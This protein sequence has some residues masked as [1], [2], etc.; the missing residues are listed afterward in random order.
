MSPRPGSRHRRRARQ[1]MVAGAVVFVL[2]TLALFLARPR[3]TAYVPGQDAE[4]NREI[5]RALDRTPGPTGGSSQPGAEG[6]D[7]AAAAAAGARDA[8]PARADDGTPQ[9][10]ARAAVPGPP[11]GAAAAPAA[12]ATAAG[13]TGAGAAAAGVTFS[14]VAEA[15]GLRFT[16]FSGRRSTQLPEDMGSGLAWGDYDGDGWP[17][18]FVVNE[19]GPLTMSPAELAASPAHAQLFHNAGGRFVD[20]TEQA[21]LAVRGIGMGA[22]WGDYDGDGRLD[23][24]VTRFGTNLLFR[25]EGHGRFRD[26]SAETGIDRFVGFWTGASWADYDRDGQLDLY[27]CGYVR[28]SYDAAKAVEVSHQFKAAVPYTL[29]P[30]SYPPERNLLLHN[31]GGRFVETA[32]AA[33]VDDVTG[34]SLSASWADF[35]GDGW[36]D[37]YVANDVS[38]NALFLN[39]GN[40]RFRDVSASAWVNE[41]RGSMGL[42][43]GDWDNSGRFDIFITH[44]LAQENALYHD[45]TRNMKVTPEAPLRFV[46]QADLLGLGQ[47]ALDVVGW[48]TGFFDFDDDGRLDLYAINGSTLQEEADPSR[49]AAMRSFLFRNAGEQGFYEVGQKAG[50]PFV[51]PLVGR[52]ASFADFDGDGDLDLAVVVHG[53]R[54]RLARNDG[55]NR[56]GFLRV[57]LRS[58]AAARGGRGPRS[59]RL[60]I[61][62][63]V[64]LTTAAGTQLREV[65]GQSSY[66][67]QE[68][69]G[70]VFFGTGDAARVERLEVRW[71]SGRTQAFEGLPVRSTVRITEGGA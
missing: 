47:I 32:R 65:G 1:F 53:G 19:S 35:D 44:W 59:T 14:E 36:P 55:G 39:L 71:P 57:V 41:Y 16:H 66:L 51:T 67:S 54:L 5:T 24:F 42:G 50:E 27:V 15:V 31:I 17:D 70:E 29:N 52:G 18:L 45:E 25:N 13:S 48:G 58:P 37:L 33:G 6:Q 28:Y 61:G 20:V 12:G 4:A 68:P 30:S 49:L 8:A 46:D 34:R 69:P 11:A 3:E 26:V 38:S 2:V 7:G 64:R 23:L 10:A 63:R 22:A 56:R 43:I 40:G 60:A 21:G 62:A 9:A